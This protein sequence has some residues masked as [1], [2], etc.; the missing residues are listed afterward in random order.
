ML[1]LIVPGLILPRQALADLTH[2]LPLPALSLHLGRGRLR[3]RPPGT[4]ASLLAAAS[5]LHEPLPAAALRAPQTDGAWLCLDP[6]HLRFEE[7]TLIVDDP[8]ALALTLDEAQQLAVSLAP[9]FSALGE[10]VVIT[11][12]CWNLRLAAAAPVFPS[13]SDA[14][15]RRADPLPLDA[16]SAPWRR[17]INDAQMQLHAHP[18]NQARAAAGRP[19]VNSLWPWGGGALPLPPASSCA[20]DAIW[21]DDPMAQGIA[22]YRNITAAPLPARLPDAPGKSPLAIF[23]AL[24]LPARSGNGIAWRDHIARLERDWLAPALAALK[25]G[26]LDTLRLLAP[27]DEASVELTLRKRD[28]WKFWRSPAPLD[29]LAP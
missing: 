21:N 10:I 12:S 16:A 1:T 8:A 3:H 27:G 2:D 19:V 14:L 25:A 9:T 17:A 4:T 13:L 7:R 22:R 24:E 26:R 6:I 11:P 15:L 18:V 28:L 20:H 29:I 23:D 5:G